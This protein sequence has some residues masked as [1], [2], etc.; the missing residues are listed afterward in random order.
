M[1][2]F[3]SRY[4]SS[5]MT[6]RYIPLRILSL[7]VLTCTLQYIYQK[8]LHIRGKVL[9]VRDKQEWLDRWPR[10]SSRPTRWAPGDAC[11]A[12]Q[13]AHT[14]MDRY[15]SSSRTGVQ[16]KVKKSVAA[17]VPYCTARTFGFERAVKNLRLET[18]SSAP[19]GGA[20]GAL[21]VVVVCG[22]G[23][24]RALL[25]SGNAFVAFAGDCSS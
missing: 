21:V 16:K 9:Y 25:R 14:H 10:F 20:G 12:V 1:N 4:L 3:R 23:C 6:I 22:C 5:A 15:S 8:L 19:A 24:W 2:T 13:I 17:R 18:G 7:R 11:M